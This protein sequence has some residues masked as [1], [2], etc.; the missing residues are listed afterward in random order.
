MHNTQSLLAI[1]VSGEVINP[2]GQMEDHILHY[3]GFFKEA[4]IPASYD[5]ELVGPDFGQPMTNVNGVLVPDE[6]KRDLVCHAQFKVDFLQLQD[7]STSGDYQLQKNLMAER[8]K[9]MAVLTHLVQAY[10]SGGETAFAAALNEP[11]SKVTTELLKAMTKY[12]KIP[13]IDLARTRL[14]YAQKRH[15]S[16]IF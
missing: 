11:E 6:P 1:E 12:F 10:D 2:F 8:E 14:A 13:M 7:G 16:G 9:S 3:D 15:A 5:F 4:A